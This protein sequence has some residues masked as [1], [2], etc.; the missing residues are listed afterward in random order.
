MR[1]TGACARIV[2]G[3]WGR[4]L[5][6]ILRKEKVMLYMGAAYVDDVR[7]VTDVIEKGKRWESKEKKL[8]FKEE[9]EKEDKESKESDERRT[10]KQIENMM[11]SV[12]RNIQFEMEIPED[13]E[14]KRLPTL[15]FYLWLEDQKENA[16][17]NES[18]DQILMYSFLKKP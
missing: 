16:E 14:K 17:K 18:K 10:S 4:E 5:K 1:L 11:N 9:W 13:F 7:T 12:F 3:V 6:K 8:V 15:D 2:M